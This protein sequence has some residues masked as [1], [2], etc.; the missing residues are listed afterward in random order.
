MLDGM[1]KGGLEVQGENLP[2]SVSSCPK[3]VF[4]NIKKQPEKRRLMVHLINMDPGMKRVN[5]TGMI[6]QVPKSDELNVF[7]PDT[8][9]KLGF[10]RISDNV[11]FSPRDFD[12]H[13][14]IVVEY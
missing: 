4:V 5:G 9:T 11:I 13:D 3:N 10:Q 7:Y 1:V 2:V 6:V 8:N 14:M 12:V